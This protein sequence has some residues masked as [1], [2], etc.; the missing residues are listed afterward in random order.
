MRKCTI[1]GILA[2]VL[3][4]VNAPAYERTAMQQL[5]G[6][7]ALVQGQQCQYGYSVPLKMMRL[8]QPLF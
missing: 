7:E 3:E 5:L 8:P 6:R 4:R 2:I 1:C